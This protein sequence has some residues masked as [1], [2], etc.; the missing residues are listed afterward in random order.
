MSLEHAPEI[1]VSW[2]GSE[3]NKQLHYTKEVNFTQE[4]NDSQFLLC[5][6]H[7]SQKPPGF[8]EMLRANSVLTVIN[9]KEQHQSDS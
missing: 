5:D 9:F 7:V 1:H 8:L 2:K 6:A 3:I 4:Y